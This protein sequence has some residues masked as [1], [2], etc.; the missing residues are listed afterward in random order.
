MHAFPAAGTWTADA[1]V[2]RPAASQARPLGP[3][4][5]LAE[6]IV[7]VTTEADR[8]GDAE[9]FADAYDAAQRQQAANEALITEQPG[10]AKEGQRRCAVSCSIDQTV[11]GRAAC[12]IKRQQCLTTVPRI[13][14][15]FVARHDLN[16]S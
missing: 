16:G 4:E 14:S 13:S 15:L 10:P 11:S 6:Y 1:H 8:H 2:A 7:D 5:A 12:A 9:R 3:G